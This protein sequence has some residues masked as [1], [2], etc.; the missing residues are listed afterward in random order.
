M[1]ESNTI[2]NVNYFELFLLTVDIVKTIKKYKNIKYFIQLEILFN[3][4]KNNDS[5]K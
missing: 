5:I 4:L 1:F 3:V 2:L